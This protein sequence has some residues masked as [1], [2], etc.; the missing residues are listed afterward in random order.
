MITRRF[1][2]FLLLAFSALRVAAQ[3]PPPLGGARED[4]LD[5]R[6]AAAAIS[7]MTLRG[8][9]KESPAASL[10]LRRSLPR[11]KGRAAWR[12]PRQ[13]WGVQA[14]LD[15]IEHGEL[16]RL[17]GAASGSRVSLT[18]DILDRLPEA[19]RGPPSS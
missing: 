7:P 15:V 9:A 14:R 1:A 10:A 12:S 18:F 8:A 5:V 19:E 13:E 3:E 4:T 17:A 2:L 6:R 11:R 16:P